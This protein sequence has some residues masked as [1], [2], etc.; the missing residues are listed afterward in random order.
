MINTEI[1]H[2]THHQ[3]TVLGF[4]KKAAVVIVIAPSVAVI[5]CA[6]N[7][8]LVESAADCYKFEK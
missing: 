5:H 3:V 7:E 8:I 6:G 2:S 4:S 1:K